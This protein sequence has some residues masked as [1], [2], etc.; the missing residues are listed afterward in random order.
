MALQSGILDSSKTVLPPGWE[1]HLLRSGAPLPAPMVPNTT[2]KCPRSPKCYARTTGGLQRASKMKT[3]PIKPASKSASQQPEIRG[4]R[5]GAK[6]L[7]YIYIYRE[8]E[9]YI[10]IYTYMY[11]QTYLCIYIH[12]YIYIYMIN[13]PK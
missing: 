7:G 12:I 6:P 9:R 13:P 8:R 11:K 3:K 4:R 5:Q 10:Y 2:R 1:S